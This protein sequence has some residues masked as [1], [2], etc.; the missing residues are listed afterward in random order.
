MTTLFRG[1]T[2]VLA[3]VLA[4]SSPAYAA[5]GRAV[6]VQTARA[7]APV[8]RA[9]PGEQTITIAQL[10]ETGDHTSFGSRPSISY[11]LPI[12]RS[13][14]SVRFHATVRIS[15]AVDPNST[16]TLSSGGDP[17]WSTSVGELR[18]SNV[19]DVALPIPDIAN[20]SMDASLSGSFVHVGDERCSRY[21]PTSLYLVVEQGS[22]FVVD[23]DPQA[24]STIA[25]FLET[26]SGDIT[27][28][29]P[30]GSDLH[31]KLL[32]VRLAYQIE[33]LYR[34]RKASVTLSEAP[35]PHARNIVLGDYPTDLAVVGNTLE[36]GQD[37][38]RLLTRQIDPLLITTTVE[39]ADLASSPAGVASSKRISLGDLGISDETLPGGNP[40]FSMPFSVGQ[41]GGLPIGLRLNATIAHTALSGDARANV[42]VTI[43]GALVDSVPL[44]TARGQQN[45]E[46]AIPSDLVSGANDVRLTV[47]YDPA[48]NCNV[49]EPTFTTTVF[50]TTN[51]HWDG[52]TTYTPSVGD[53]IRGAA[54]R[55][56]V[57]VENDQLVP[58]AFSLLK[59]IGAGNTNIA[60]IDVR[61]FTGTVPEGYDAAIVV[62]PLARLGA[63]PL[64]LSGNG[65]RFGLAKNAPVLDARFEDPFGVL[66]TAR[67]GTTPTLV[68]S[69]YRDL[70][71]IQGLDQFSFTTLGDQSDRIFIFRGS[72]ALYASTAPRPRDIPQPLLNRAALPITAGVVVLICGVVILARR[73]RTGGRV[74]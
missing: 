27:V 52:I 49:A 56:V 59:T 39:S 32:A 3:I 69:Y 33:Q 40:T 10:G 15:P 12:Y 38:D 53:F 66:E 19:I 41:V 62:A 55:V 29:V 25:G 67:I 1:L 74:A 5:A 24:S 48:R 43:N 28:V 73:K 4:L 60:A 18:K 64:L 2:L 35:D 37:G 63:W 51:F 13:L 58:Y 11:Y 45:V 30:P 57:L 6:P 14:R 9:Q 16:V 72:Q 70:A 8:H 47:N 42:E 36:V 23:T 22:G 26:Y 17:V 71:A 68:A 54:G 65:D 44:V 20:R 7:K 31:H 61:P 50:A 46:V 21:D 34:W